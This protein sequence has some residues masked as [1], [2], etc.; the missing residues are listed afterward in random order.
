MS[1]N[2]IVSIYEKDLMEYGFEEYPD[3]HFDGL[4]S[5]PPYGLNFMGKKW[6]SSVPPKEFWEKIYRVMKPGA[7]L[8]VFGGT[9]TFHRLAVAI[10]DSGFEIRDTMMWIYGSGFPK[11]RH[12]Y[13]TDL[14]KSIEEQL[15]EKTGRK[16]IEWK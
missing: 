10:E 15:K 16:N 4:V 6:D 12:I 7:H 9:R 3:N 14:L 5:D 2:T 11:G 8:L 1:K 13:K